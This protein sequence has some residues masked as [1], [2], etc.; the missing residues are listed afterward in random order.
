M[1]FLR[2]VEREPL[3]ENL[4]NLKVSTKSQT[5]V[6]HL[7]RT[8]LRYVSERRLKTTELLDLTLT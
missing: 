3:F 6:Q 8:Y 1:K 7:L 5:E 4:E 2:Y